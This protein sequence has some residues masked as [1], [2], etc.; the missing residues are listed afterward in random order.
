MNIEDLK[1]TLVYLS[2]E[3]SRM[4]TMAGTLASIEK[5]HYFKLTNFDQRELIDLAIEEQ[6]ASRQLGVMRDMC[7][8]MGQKVDR[9]RLTIERGD[10]KG[11]DLHAEIH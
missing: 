4:E 11:S 1:N 10:F 6:N 2:T 8:S 5:D 9:M 3:L 7:F